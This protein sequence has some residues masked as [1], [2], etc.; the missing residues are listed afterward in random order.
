MLFAAV[1]A[2]GTIAANRGVPANG[3]A[4]AAADGTDQV[5]TVPFSGDVSKCVATANPTAALTAPLVVSPA[6]TPSTIT[7]REQG[8]NTTPVGFALQVTC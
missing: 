5:F 8:V 7:V 6:A 1:A 3:K 2:D 4:T